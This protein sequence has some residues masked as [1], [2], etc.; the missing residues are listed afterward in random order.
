[1]KRKTT[2]LFLTAALAVTGILG[3][4]GSAS[5]SSASDVAS[6]ATADETTQAEAE[7]AASDVREIHVA[8][9]GKTR[10]WTYYDD[11]DTLIG[12]DIELVQEIFSRLP[13]YKLVIDVVE[14]SAIF[15]GIDSGIYQIGAN[16]YAKTPEREEKYLFTLPKVK[17]DEVLLSSTIN[18]DK[19]SYTLSE[20]TDYVYTL[21]PGALHTVEAEMYNE[22]NP[23]NQITLNYT[24]EDLP[25]I[26]Q[27]VQSG[28]YELFSTAKA[29]Y[30]GA[31]K[32]LFGL[33][34]NTATLDYGR[35]Q[36]YS[37][38]IV[39][40]GEEQLVEDINAVL[41][42][43]FAEGYFK[44]LSDKYIGLDMVPYDAYK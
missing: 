7:G 12:Y 21:E 6:K 14:G 27:S 15:S 10:P 16:N 22:A 4:C 26:L 36:P 2:A 42:D 33:T 5:T 43:L 20:L 13:Q 9:G 34:L 40:K 44:E 30:F 28:K 24:E 29:M 35:G 25:T 32:D 39:G 37:Y 3:G 11:N 18:F 1:M 31:Y 38:L 23:D 41:K 17:N 8:T 19:E